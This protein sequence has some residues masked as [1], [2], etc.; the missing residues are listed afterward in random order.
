MSA[1]EASSSCTHPFPVSLEIQL[2]LLPYFPSLM[3]SSLWIACPG[4][5]LEQLL[6]VPRLARARLRPP[7]KTSSSSM[8]GWELLVASIVK[9]MKRASVG[10]KVSMLRLELTGGRKT[11]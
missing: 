10:S 2:W 3:C 1:G 8:Q 7:E 4:R 11:G 6:L 9:R 5:E